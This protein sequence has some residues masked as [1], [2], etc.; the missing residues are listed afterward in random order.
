MLNNLHFRQ[1]SNHTFIPSMEDKRSDTIV[2][3][4]IL[5]LPAEIRLKIYRHLL[6]RDSGSCTRMKSDYDGRLPNCLYPA[7]LSTCH[8]IRGEA[9]NVLYGENFFLAH[10][11]VDSNSNAGLITRATFVISSCM[12]E[13]REM[14]VSGLKEFL[15]NH[16]NLKSLEL[17]FDQD[18]LDD[19]MRDVLANT[20]RTTGY[21]SELS[22]LADF[23]SAISYL[24]A[25]RLLRTVKMGVS[26]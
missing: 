17:Q 16:P 11:I 14:E 8:L 9:M 1:D 5:R 10:R 3:P 23:K 4:P 25:L 24:N 22:I 7:I 20:F 18:L 12:F 13:D 19:N 6:L 2:Q 26:T 15:Y 21:S